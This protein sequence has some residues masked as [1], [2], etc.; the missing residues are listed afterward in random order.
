[1]CK[2]YIYFYYNINKF[3]EKN[4]YIIIIIN[5]GRRNNVLPGTGMHQSSNPAIIYTAV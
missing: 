1:M 5:A 3:F 2:L 4:N